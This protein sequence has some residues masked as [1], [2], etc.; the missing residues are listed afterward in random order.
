MP[1]MSVLWLIWDQ[2]KLI[3][4]LLVRIRVSGV[5]SPWFFYF[6]SFYHKIELRVLSTFLELFMVSRQIFDAMHDD[7][8][9]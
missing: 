1:L 8:L 2:L 3:R 4:V 9:C 5:E 7:M 6:T